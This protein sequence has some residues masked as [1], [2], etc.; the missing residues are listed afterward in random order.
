[1]GARIARVRRRE[2]RP[3][4]RP[5]RSP[6]ETLGDPDAPRADAGTRPRRR[7]P[8]LGHVRGPARG[9]PEAVRRR[10]GCRRRGPRHRRRRVLLDARPIGLGQD[11]DVADDRG[12]RA[13]VGRTDP[14]PRAGRQ[15]A[16]PLRARREHGLP[17]L[18]PVPAHD[19]RRQRRLRA[20]DPEGP[21]G[22]PARSGHR[23]APDGPARRLREAQAVAVVGRP[24]P[25]SRAGPGARQPAPRPPAR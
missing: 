25:A 9:G 22:C 20:D 12:F 5:A 8:R 16:G 21:Q 3:P 4:A 15:P 14:A 7:Q 13:S 19:R 17:G 6:E 1:M 18:R 10:R 11:H 24:A 23:G 2:I